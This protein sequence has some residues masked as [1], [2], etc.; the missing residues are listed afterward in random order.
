MTNSTTELVSATERIYEG[1]ILNLRIDTIVLPN[2]KSAKREIVEHHGAVAIV[3]L[4]DKETVVMVRQYRHPAEQA[5]LEVP[6]G[7]LEEDED[8][9]GCARRELTEEVNLRAKHV[10]KLHQSYV[11]PGYSTEL[12][13]TFLAY[14]LTEETGKPDEDE[15]IDVE[16]IKLSEVPGMIAR[17]EI[18]DGKSIG[19]LLAVIALLPTLKFEQDASPEL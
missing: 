3:P 6:A 17:G 11:A 10:I 5:L 1:R 4:I 9:E 18:Q 16:H 7:G 2:G 15:F 12:I 8:I 19:G 14:G 13:H